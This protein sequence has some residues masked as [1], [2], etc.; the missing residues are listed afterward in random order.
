MAQPRA[1]D[2]N[3]ERQRIQVV[4]DRRTY[5]RRHSDVH[6]IVSK[7][8]KK[9]GLRQSAKVVLG[10]TQ[11]LMSESSAK[12]TFNNDLWIFRWPL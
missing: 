2:F 9:S 7:S 6:T 1:D 4:V 11:P 10:D 3:L 5:L 12:R 8:T